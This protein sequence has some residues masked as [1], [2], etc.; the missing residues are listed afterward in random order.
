MTLCLANL[1]NLQ[2]PCKL[3]TNNQLDMGSFA[4]SI[5]LNILIGTDP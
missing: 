1:T 2:P 4:V 3:L 5:I